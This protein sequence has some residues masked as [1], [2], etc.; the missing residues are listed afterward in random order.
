MKGFNAEEYEKAKKAL[1]Q[2]SA[3]S[4]ATP[5]SMMSASGRKV[6]TAVNRVDVPDD[7]VGNPKVK[8][9]DTAHEFHSK[10]ESIQTELQALFT[11]Y[12][13]KYTVD[14]KVKTMFQ[15]LGSIYTR[16]TNTLK[17]QLTDVADIRALYEARITEMETGHQD[18]L[19]VIRQEEADR[20]R[21]LKE[22]T[23]R[24]HAS[25]LKKLKI[26]LKAKYQ[27]KKELD[28]R[29]E[30]KYRAKWLR[31]YKQ[32]QLMGEERQ[33][34]NSAAVE[35]KLAQLE[36]QI[37]QAASTHQKEVEQVRHECAQLTQANQE[38]Q[39]S[40]AAKQVKTRQLGIAN[41]EARLRAVEAEAASQQAHKEMAQLQTE[42]S[43]LR[44]SFN[45]DKTL[46]LQQF[47]EQVRHA[48]KMEA[49]LRDELRQARAEL[50]RSAE[51]VQQAK[52]GA[53]A[54]MA[55]LS[56]KHSKELDQVHGRILLLVKK[57]DKQIGDL[58]GALAESSAKLARTEQFLQKQNKELADF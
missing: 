4:R 53:A 57:K 46:L 35:Q 18:T 12:G 16:T 42:V 28:P 40:L 7:L 17:A 25:E 13:I 2:L 47:Q 10:V 58:K 27:E 9:L 6:P 55:T 24:A 20:I 54:D 15:Q 50:T 26:D 52:E 51:A 11:K 30:E 31:E 48:T 39:D 23:R 19:R 5:K 37:T 56:A 44:A 8:T 32:Q 45:S 33:E 22:Q 3:G 49:E 43:S 14:A 1:R 29:L 34:Q 41:Q 38:L 36:Q 21:K